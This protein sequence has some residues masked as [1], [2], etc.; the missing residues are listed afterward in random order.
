MRLESFGV[1]SKDA[2]R[3]SALNLKL[4]VL[5]NLTIKIRGVRTV[6]HTTRGGQ[7]PPPGKIFVKDAP[8]G[9]AR[10]GKFCPPLDPENT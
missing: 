7:V 4:F 2:V 5:W 6:A 1:T 3:I 10:G 8:P 9:G